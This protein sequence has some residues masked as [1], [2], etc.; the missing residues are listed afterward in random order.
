VQYKKF[1][2]KKERYKKYFGFLDVVVRFDVQ[3]RV[4][5]RREKQNRR[6]YA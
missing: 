1:V 4:Y 2:F 5:Y 6:D 3:Q